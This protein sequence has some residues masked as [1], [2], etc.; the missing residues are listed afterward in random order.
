MS[1]ALDLTIF[2]GVFALAIGLIGS[3]IGTTNE[4]NRELR[5]AHAN[6]RYARQPWDTDRPNGRGNR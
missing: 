5:A 2:A 1:T 3:F 4:K 6:R